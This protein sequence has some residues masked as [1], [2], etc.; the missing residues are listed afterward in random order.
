MPCDLNDQYNAEYV[1]I[2]GNFKTPF[3][4]RE[5]LNTKAILQFIGEFFLMYHTIIVTQTL[6]IAILMYPRI[7]IALLIMSL[8]QVICLM[9]SYLII[10]Y[11][12]ML[13]INLLIHQ[14]F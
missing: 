1:C 2:G 11:V 7:H 5:S 6:T 12:M 13:K 9:L 10:V 14:L 4:K 3:F 8:F